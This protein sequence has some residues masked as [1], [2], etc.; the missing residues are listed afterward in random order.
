[1]K[2]WL[3]YVWL[4]LWGCGGQPDTAR[5]NVLLIT[6]DTTRADHLATY[7]YFRETTPH[8]DRLAGESVVFDQF[9]VPMATT[10][11]THT[12]IFTGAWPLEHGVLANIKHGGMVHRSS[13]SLESVVEVFQRAGYRTAG[14][15]SAS[16]LKR[17]TGVEQGFKNFDEPEA[18]SRNAFRTV[19]RARGWLRR[20]S[21][22]QARPFFLWVH[23][24]DPHTPLAPPPPYDTLYEPDPE[25]DAFLRERAVS[26]SARVSGLEVDP[27]QTTNLYDGELSYM[28]ACLGPLL[29]DLAK[30]EWWDQTVV[31][32]AGDHGEGLG[33]HGVAGHGGVWGEQI[34]AP[35]WIRAASLEPGRRSFPVTAVD[36]MP[37][38][39]SW[40]KLEGAEQFL[41]QSSGRDVLGAAPQRPILHLPADRHVPEPSQATKALTVGGTRYR[42]GGSGSLLFDLEEDA[43]ELHD[44]ASYWP[45][46]HHYMGV[47]LEDMEREQRARG[48]ALGRASPSSMDADRIE[49]LEALGYVN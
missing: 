13:E 2:S 12:S 3:H 5:Q 33:G 7:G 17:G 30:A 32:V 26:P 16:P 21:S 35:L 19:D 8:L 34:H 18:P 41:A 27:V 20:W 40:L 46:T 15:V 36:V 4:V 23:L 39:V 24:F 28:D 37:T 49:E 29:Q 11:P 6:L 43:H 22:H 42:A 9:L 10:L 44:V 1:M 47:W 38:L 14:F 45:L 25:L 48:E 31:V